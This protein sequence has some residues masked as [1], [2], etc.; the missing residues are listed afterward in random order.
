MDSENFPTERDLHGFCGMLIIAVFL[1]SVT[2]FLR[3]RNDLLDNAI[4]ERKLLGFMP[5]HAVNY[6]HQ[7][8]IVGKTQVALRRASLFC[9][10]MFLALS[11]MAAAMST[12]NLS[13][14]AFT[15]VDDFPS[16]LNRSLGL[17]KD[18]L[19]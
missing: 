9:L 8:P 2:A 6:F 13:N 15:P 4:A 7:M 5:R 12:R 17:P 19:G 1:E 10:C 14:Q 18:K 3:Y 16:S 11:A